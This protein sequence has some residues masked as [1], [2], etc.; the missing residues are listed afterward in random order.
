M[1]TTTFHSIRFAAVAA[2]I[3]GVL[4]V[5][6]PGRSA[7]EPGIEVSDPSWVGKTLEHHLGKRVKL[8]LRSGQEVEGTV[9]KVGAQAVHVAQLAGMEFFDAGVRLDDVSAVVV[10]ARS[11]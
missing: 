6:A 7:D 4:L 8:K 2:C 11:K 9:V 1:R 5:A 10:R 3:L